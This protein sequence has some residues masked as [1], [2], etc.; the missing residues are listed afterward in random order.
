MADQLGRP[1]PSISSSMVRASGGAAA[2]PHLLAV[3]PCFAGAGAGAGAG[4]AAAS[5][6]ATGWHADALNARAGVTALYIAAQQGH[7]KVA[8]QLARAGADLNKPRHGLGASFSG[9][10]QC[11]DAVP[12]HPLSTRRGN[13]SFFVG[14]NS[15]LT[16][17]LH[18]AGTTPLFIAS[19]KGHEA[20][21]QELVAAGANLNKPR[22]K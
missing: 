1:L 6:Q 2:A 3:V 7:E 12:P 16:F 4:D 17:W 5:D 19:Q 8:R 18:V 13:P 22:A 11:F 15:P 20:V 14:L 9:A 10:A 21:V